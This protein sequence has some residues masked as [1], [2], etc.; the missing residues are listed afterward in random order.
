MV[1][2]GSICQAAHTLLH[3]L[4]SEVLPTAETT[5]K[6][7]LDLTDDMARDASFYS[8]DQIDAYSNVSDSAGLPIY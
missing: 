5:V 2:T 7:L 8:V 6:R 3:D 1:T 4:F